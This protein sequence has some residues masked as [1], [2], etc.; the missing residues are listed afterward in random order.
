M[1]PPLV[2][3]ED[4]LNELTKVFRE[5]GLEGATLTRISRATGLGKASLYHHFPGGKQ[6]MALA[7]VK[8][9]N[10]QLQEK[11]I[12][13]LQGDGEPTARI[14]QMM[15][16]LDKYY[17]S[18]KES[19]LLGVLTVTGSRGLFHEHIKVGFATWI[20]SLASVLVEAGLPKKLATT[21][22]ENA[23]FSIE[24]ALVVC[25]GLGNVASFRRLLRE[26][27]ADLLREVEDPI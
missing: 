22:A 24:G 3:K 14:R 21:R 1:R 7:V 8:R 27:S 5:S 19:C 15:R 11:V 6:E 10:L 17:G 12:G 20:K 18:G 23:I 4:V 26:L 16:N 13:P 25:R 9:S 2:P